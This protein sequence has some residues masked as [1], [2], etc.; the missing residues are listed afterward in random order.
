MLVGTSWCPDTRVQLFC[1]VITVKGLCGNGEM[2]INH[3]H[4]ENKCDDV[5]TISTSEMVTPQTVTRRL[6]R[7][8][9]GNREMSRTRTRKR[10]QWK[11][12]VVV[13]SWRCGVV[14]TVRCCG[15]IQAIYITMKH[16]K[17][18]KNESAP[19][20]RQVKF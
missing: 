2:W 14:V 12:G 10:R 20:H 19:R 7:A 13:T 9:R 17:H 3:F 18:K 5:P 1:H 15:D 4:V 6:R 11:S 16:Q 8:S